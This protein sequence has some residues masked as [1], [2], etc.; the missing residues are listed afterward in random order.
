MR[1][2][3]LPV[4]KSA[5]R[6]IWAIRSRSYSSRSIGMKRSA[7]EIITAISWEGIPTRCKRPEQPLDPADQIGGK[8]GHRQDRG[9]DDE[10][11]K[12]PC[13]ISPLGKPLL[14]DPERQGRKR[15]QRP[16]FGQKQMHEEN[17]RHEDRDRPH[18]RRRL[19]E[20]QAGG[21]KDE[22]EKETDQGDS[23]RRR[24]ENE[25]TH[26]DDGNDFHPRIETMDDRLP[27]QVLTQVDHGAKPSLMADPRRDIEAD[28]LQKFG[29]AEYFSRRPLDQD[30]APWSMTTIRSAPATSR[31]SWAMWMIA[32]PSRCSLRMMSRTRCFPAGSR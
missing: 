19:R 26:Q 32:I 8:R 23:C 27:R 6:A 1:S 18:R 29:M 10:T 4:V 5:P 30:A 24:R 31:M 7:I 15:K 17:E 28:G 9:D 22:G 2:A 21:R 3:R 13:D 16:A 25:E 20:R 12:L 11:G 14:C